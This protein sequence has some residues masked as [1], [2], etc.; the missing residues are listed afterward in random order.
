MVTD[1]MFGQE[2]MAVRVEQATVEC[3]HAQRWLPLVDDAEQLGKPWPEHA[4]EGKEG[5]ME[6][7]RNLLLQPIKIICLS[8]GVVVLQREQLSRFS[9]EDKEHPVEEDKGRS[10]E[11]RVGKECRSRWSQ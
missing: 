10:E 6:R 3:G 1:S 8:V 7:L 2:W 5:S 9:V 11:R 4:T